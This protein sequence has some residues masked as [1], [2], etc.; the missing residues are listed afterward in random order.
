MG[1]LDPAAGL[2]AAGVVVWSAFDAG[3][4]FPD[5]P[6]WLAVLFAVLLVL[7]VSLARHPFEGVGA[8]VG[9]VVGAL[10]LLA[11]WTLLSG[12]WSGA[13]ARALLEFDRTL[14]Y[15]LALVFFGSLPGSPRRTRWLVWSLAA[16]FAAVAAI[17]LASR[18]L[19]AVWPIEQGYVADRLSYPLTYWNG[20][21]I[22]AAIGCL[23]NVHLA[24]SEREPA[25]ARA[26][27]AAAAP[28]LAVTVYFT[29]S[30]GAIGALAIGLVVYLVVGRPRAMV[31]GLP[32][33]VV[34]AAV[35]LHEA[36]AADRV[37]SAAFQSAAAQQQGR[38]VA[39]VLAISIAL[40]FGVRLL[41][42]VWIDP[43]VRRA[44]PGRRLRRAGAVALVAAASAGIAALVLGGAPRVVTRQVELFFTKPAVSQ[45]GDTRRH[46]TDPS[47]NYR[48]AAWEVS[49]RSFRSA[50]ITGTGAGTFQLRWTRERPATKPIQ[51]MTDGHSLY[52]EV[53]GELGV[54]GLALLVVALAAIAV[55]ML[56]AARRGD[57]PL[58]A[59]LL[60]ATVAWAVHA[61]ADWD[62][63]MSAVTVWLFAAAGTVLAASGSGGLRMPLPSLA[64]TVAGLGG[65]LL[66]VLP[67]SIAVSERDLQHAVR[68][69][70]RGDCA[71]AIDRALGSAAALS[72]R[73]EPYAVLGYCDARLAPQLGVQMMRRAVERDPGFWE[74]RYG[75]AIA[76][77]AAGQDPKPA[78]DAAQRLDPLEP[79]VREARRLFAG[80]QG[81]RSW[82]RRALDARLPAG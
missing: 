82:R 37:S 65:L 68:A 44:R 41:L 62:W 72:A 59:A 66:A 27:G 15:A 64:R 78:L 3:G 75:L 80:A 34:A 6:A 12:A 76:R 31:T 73:P 60:A 22:F 55:G 19:P 16:A 14:A 61:G 79:L 32:P 33:L 18:L 8:A 43:R 24:C 11:A 26:L 4:F 42:A 58:H 46:L 36:Y 81:P 25:L 57:R 40:A 9:V 45:T 30:R 28:L 53:L 70:V 47:S 39:L 67:G 1:L 52:L 23:L 54:V 17:A 20:V 77:A 56:R 74:Y 50:P 63:E 10:G 49:L 2:L 71:T 48:V 51:A 7:R 35:S 13:P 5:A 69:L 21:G 38:H 29:F